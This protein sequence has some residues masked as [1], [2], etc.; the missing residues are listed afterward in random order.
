MRRKFWLSAAA[1]AAWWGGLVCNL[2]M[3]ST[4]AVA[5]PPVKVGTYTS[6]AKTFSTASYW[7]EGSQGVVLIDTQFLPKEGLEAVDAAEK[8][9]GKKVVLAVVLHPNPDKFNGTAV[10]QARGIRVVTAQQVAA[11]IPA[12]H[13]IRLGWF[14]DEYAP[15]YPKEAA[16]PSVFGSQTTELEAGGVKLKLHVLGAGA[17]AAHVVAQVQTDAGVAVFAGDLINPDNHAWLELGLINDWLK[18]LDDIKAMQ[19]QRVF[20]GRG[21]AGGAE[22]IERQASYLKFAQQTVR[23]EKPEGTPSWLAK[24]R[25][26]NK[27]EAQYPNL[28]YPIFMRDGVEAVWANEAKRAR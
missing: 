25:I 1:V 27:I 7:L 10:M 26:V 2:M 19:P 20:P 3:F 24:R 12:V 28:G 8:A 4:M 6:P 15:H 11:A 14:F 22:L 16:K 23:D 17:S 18:R 5:Q 21:K 13:V 9:T